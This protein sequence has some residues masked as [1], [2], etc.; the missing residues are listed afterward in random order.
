LVVGPIAADVVDITAPVGDNLAR[1]AAAK[2]ERIADLT[3]CLLDR[4]RHD[5]LVREVREAGARIK[6]ITDGDVAGAIMAA[7]EGT[8]IDLLLGVGGTPEG[9]IT[10]CAIKCMGGTIQAMLAPRDDAERQQALDAGHDLSKV[11]TTDDLVRSDNVFFC[12]TGITD[13]E[14]MRGV[15]YRS[16]GAQTHSIVMRSK[17]G[18]I[19]EVASDHRL[20]KLMMYS[21]VDFDGG[22]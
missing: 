20:D 9:I 17:S 12:A 5:D 2:S 21:S 4:P 1:I 7:R 13:G 15:R 10:A 11:L 3:V 22:P 18:T 14:L 19:R 6:F 16:Q 8:G